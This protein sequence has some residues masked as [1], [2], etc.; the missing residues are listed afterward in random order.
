MPKPQSPFAEMSDAELVVH[1]RSH[2][3]TDQGAATVEAMM[4][5]KSS[6]EELSSRLIVLNRALVFLTIVVAIETLAFGVL[7]FIHSAL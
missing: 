4:R 6:N 1:A 5:L 7:G 3:G 2:G